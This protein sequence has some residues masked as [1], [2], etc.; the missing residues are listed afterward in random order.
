MLQNPL[1]QEP[2]S[3]EELHQL[4]T[5]V[6]NQ[7][8]LE[9]EIARAEDELAAK[10]EQLKTLAEI[11]IPETLLGMGL[12]ELKL[13]TGEIVSV[14]KF[15]ACK[16]PDN[17]ADEAFDWLRNSGNGDII[18]NNLILNFGKGEDDLAKEVA[19]ELLKRGL[20]PEQK[21]FVHPMTLKSFVRERIENNEELPTNL[22][23]VFVGNKTKVSTPKKTTTK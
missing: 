4:S 21:I 9:A 13:S 14:T 2:I 12:S 1:T 20:S 3:N 16:I 5:M 10:K 18:K 6:H 17:C 19:Q 7:V 15:Y 11:K 23:G 8:K 22:F